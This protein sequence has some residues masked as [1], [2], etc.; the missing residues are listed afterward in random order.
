[1]KAVMV[2]LNHLA[3]PLG[4]LVLSALELGLV[5]AQSC[6]A[7]GGSTAYQGKYKSLGCYND[8]SVSILSDAK[9]STIAMTPQYCTDFCGARG[10]QYGG[11]EFTT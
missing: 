5:H 10:Y 3:G 8:S 6:D 1:M 7:S 4:L 11:V 2:A 9:V